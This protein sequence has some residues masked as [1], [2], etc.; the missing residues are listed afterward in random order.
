MSF[1][2][3]ALFTTGAVIGGLIGYAA[4]R[5]DTVKKATKCTIKAGIKAKD[6]TVD[7]FHKAKDEVKTMAED[8]KKGTKDVPQVQDA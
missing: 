4:V 8:A 5:S 6:W 3:I 7:T 2:K 1:G